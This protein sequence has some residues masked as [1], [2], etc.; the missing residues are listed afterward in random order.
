M[1]F[2]I[3]YHSKDLLEQEIASLKKH[4]P[5]PHPTSLNPQTFEE[6]TPA[7]FGA[8]SDVERKL[9]VNNLELNPK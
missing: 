8:L 7:Y 1:L 3:E 6:L 4:L 9:L 2:K 5:S